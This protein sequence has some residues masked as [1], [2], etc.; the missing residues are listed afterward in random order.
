MWKFAET[1]DN[2]KWKGLTWG[3]LPLHASGICACTYHFFY[4]PS[5]LQFL[6]TSQAG[7]T[8][9]GNITCMIAAFRIA[10]SNGW[11][12]SEINPFPQKS[13][14]PQGLVADG[15]AAMPLKVDD[16]MESGAVLAGKIVS[17]TL[18]AS[19]LVKY[20]ELGLD[21][22][23]TPNPGV[24]VAMIVGIP[25]LTAYTYYSKSEVNGEK[26]RFALPSFGNKDGPSLSMD[27]VKKYGKAG[28][29]AY[30]LTELAFWIVAFPVASYALYNSTGHW[31][32]V[33]NDNTDRA[34]VLG[35]YLCRRQHCASLCARTVGCG[36]GLGSVGGRE[37]VGWWQR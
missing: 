11:T 13:T 16:N 17:L 7:L 30:V 37:L 32:D 21:L 20:G 36:I 25:A 15:L 5:A 26:P 22:P 12:I 24:A 29:V 23:F 9:L 28:T 35:F 4:N 31:P 6:V 34:A 19:Y 14:N 27:D 1:T 3:M 8:L 10:T 33:L 18:F 2:P